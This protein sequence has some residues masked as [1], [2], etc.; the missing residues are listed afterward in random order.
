MST[1]STHASRR[2]TPGAAHFAAPRPSLARRGVLG[3]WA[4]LT[5]SAILGATTATA[6]ISNG[7][8]ENGDLSSWTAG[9]QASVEAVQ[10]S[11]FSPAITPVDGAW[12]ALLSTGPGNTGGGA[13]D[14]DS[15]GDD[16][17]DATSLS[18][19]V[20]VASANQTLSFSW[21]FLTGEQVS[22]AG[23]DDVFLVTLDGV[24]IL[25]AS[26]PIRR[27]RSPFPNTAGLDGVAYTVS[28]A[29]PTNGSDFDEGLAAFSFFCV[30]IADPGSYTLEFKVADQHDATV[31][32]GVL[33]D[34][35]ELPSVSCGDG[36]FTQLT[37]TTGGRVEAKGGA[38]EFELSSSSSPAASNDGKTFTFVSDADLL[39]DNPSLVDQL[40]SWDGASYTRLT[41]N[42]SGELFEP[43]LTSNGTW[44][45]F[46][47]TSDLTGANSDLNRE[48]FRCSVASCIGTLV[49]VTDTTSCNNETPSIAS[50]TTGGFVAFETDCTDLAPGFNADG[51]AEVVVW[52]ESGGGFDTFET[53]G[54]GSQEPSLS[55]HDAATYVSFTSDCD[56]T[57]GNSD[58]NFEI[59]QW[60]RVGSSFTQI[61]TS[62]GSSN[63]GPWSSHD[64]SLVSFLSNADYDTGNNAAN[65][66]LTFLWNRGTNTL[67]QMSP[68]GV[69]DQDLFSSLDDSGAWIA[70]ERLG[71]FTNQTGIHLIDTA[72]PRT[73]LDVVT[74][75]AAT[76]TT[77]PIVSNNGV[78][79]TIVLPSRGDLAGNNGDGNQEI[80]TTVATLGGLNN[81]I[82]CSDPNLA[83]PDDDPTGVTDTLS[84]AAIGTITDLDVLLE[85]DH[86]WV[87]D[88]VVELDNV[89]G[90]TSATL[91]DR[92]GRRNRGLGCEED[93]I[94]VTLDRSAALQAEDA[95]DPTSP[96]IGGIL[97]PN[98]N[99]NR[100]NG[101]DLAD[102]WV[103]TVV[104][105]EASDLGTLIRWCLLVEFAAP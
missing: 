94:L 45:A 53:T 76:M 68:A 12:F 88:L 59:F 13:Q 56:F 1:V 74:A 36:A 50:D 5:F 91:I 26:A 38:L 6:Q 83:I 21:A 99:L 15:N 64:G 37:Q 47:S 69:F 61:T 84:V 2:D 86:T 79:R 42:T 65:D 24:P 90:G 51:N 46:A 96:A 75:P 87:G 20:T 104:D 39:G 4:V 58:G 33:I 48:I 52:N 11:A 105:E 28:S 23:E 43:S 95:C 78:T 22:P 41:A 97:R 10:S 32:S 103:L 98:D 102:D 70:I 29:G 81:T 30:Q 19:T 44:L 101:N 18:T 80:F 92:P 66:L 60:D 31:D 77:S 89:T 34:H 72:N 63:T 85:I 71:L 54:C 67:T 3:P 93:D 27:N 17:F 9:G 25:T 49:Q 82:I 16:D 7:S 55:T 62:T 35:V 73:L 100:F 40:Y 8:F 14:I 57:G